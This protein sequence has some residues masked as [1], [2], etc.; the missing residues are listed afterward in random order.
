MTEI[1]YIGNTTY[2]LRFRNGTHEVVECDNFDENNR[3]VV[4]SGWYEKCRAF[5]NDLE[6]AHL[7]SRF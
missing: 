3:K 7:E 1:Y 5:L 6:V 4:F 2:L